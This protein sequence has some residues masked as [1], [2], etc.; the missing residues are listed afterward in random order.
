MLVLPPTNCSK[1]FDR[2]GK[3]KFQ[4]IQ[5]AQIQNFTRETF[6]PLSLSKI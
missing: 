4:M 2:P 6:S 3:K 1:E 5:I